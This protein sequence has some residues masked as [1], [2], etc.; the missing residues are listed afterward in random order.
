MKKIVGLIFTVFTLFTLSA[1]GTSI[2][3]DLQANDWNI[4]QGNGQS[5]TA[6]FSTDTVTISG[7]LGLTTGYNYELNEDETEILFYT[8]EN[9]ERDEL[10]YSIEE[11]GENE[12]VFNSLNSE[13]EQLT[14]TP[15]EEE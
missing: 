10:N 2:H 7:T 9:G 15:I 11:Q 5:G 1:C 14:F 12:I 13:E 3:E 8:E 4:V 6:Q